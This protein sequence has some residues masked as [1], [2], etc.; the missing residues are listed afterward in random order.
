MA[1]VLFGTPETAQHVGSGAGRLPSEGEAPAAAHEKMV[2]PVEGRAGAVQSWTAAAA[3]NA[4]TEGQSGHENVTK[5]PTSLAQLGPKMVNF[6]SPVLC[7]DSGP[8]FWGHL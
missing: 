6:A 8:R 2:S 3:G 7:P 4:A 5:K 1:A